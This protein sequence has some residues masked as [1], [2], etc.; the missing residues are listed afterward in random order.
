MSDRDHRRGF[1]RN[2]LLGAAGAAAACGLEERIL[3][4]AVGEGDGSAATPK[5][6]IDPAAM[7]CGTIGKVRISRLF[8]GGNLIGGWAHSRDLMYVSRL[9]K[10]YNTEAKIFETLELAELCGVNTILI[11]PRDWDVVRKYNRERNRSFQTLVCTLPGTDDAKYGDHVKQLV[12]GGANLV[13][14]HGMVADQYVMNGRIDVLGRIVEA[15]HA[16][17]LPAGVGGHSLETPKA[18]EAN[19]LGVDYYVKTLH[20]DRYWSASP[21]EK[22]EEWCWNKPMGDEHGRYHDNMFCLNPE[23]TTDFMASVKKP[24]IAFKTMAAG[25]IHPQIAFPYAYRRGADF[26]VAGMFDF[27][28]EQDAKIAI[29]TI[30]KLDRR[31]RPW[32]G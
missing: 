24:W 2:T 26:V 28:L 23:E 4:A 30:G 29:D 11:D 18:C 27:Q 19:Q 16:Q 10:A 15:I 7:P 32:H 20:T 9:F 12:D 13:Y 8:L 17:G 1:L 21:P 25:A 3:L 31:D 5:P 22:R 6:E 14:V